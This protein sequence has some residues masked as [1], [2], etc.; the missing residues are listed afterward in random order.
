MLVGEA[1]PEDGIIVSGTRSLMLTRGLVSRGVPKHPTDHPA[2]E[3]AI[4]TNATCQG[5]PVVKG[6][7]DAFESTG[8]PVG[9]AEDSVTTF[10]AKQVDPDD[11]I[12]PHWSTCSNSLSYWVGNPPIQP[13]SPGDE[14]PGGGSPGDGSPGSP[15]G[16]SSGDGSSRPDSPHLH[17]NPSGLANDNAPLVAGTAPGAAT[18]LVFANA[19]CSGSPAVK[20]PVGQFGAGFEVQVGDNT[21]TS[22][23]A[24]SVAGGRSTCSAPVTYVEDST[25]P[26]TRITMGPGVKTRKRK[27]VFRFTD[28]TDDPP[29]TSFLCKVDRAKW[30]ACSSPLR[31]RHLRLAPHAVRVRATDLAG[32]AESKGVQRR[33]KVI[34]RP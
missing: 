26:R 30:K 17:M 31:L 32:N 9:V 33:F 16:P 24:I 8:I 27:A 28:I 5:E 29:G 2:Y 15:A 20:G 14:S 6:R 4:F 10:S 13:G 12:Q 3:I 22:F 34:R 1:E 11:P 21:S 18:V 25:A 19:N 23:S 7:A